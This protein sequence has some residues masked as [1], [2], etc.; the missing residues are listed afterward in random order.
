MPYNIGLVGCGNWSK[1]VTKEIEEHTNFNLK[2]IVCRKRN[3]NIS[4]NINIFNSI[5]EMLDN[6]DLDCIYIAA[7]PETNLEVI[8][9]SN[10]KKI[11]LILEKPLSNSYK[12]SLEIKKIYEANKSIILPNLSNVF[13]SSFNEIKKFVNLNK[14]KIKRVLIN[15]G[16]F[17]Q[18]RNKINPIWDWGFH[19]ISLIHNLFPEDKLFESNFKEI[20]KNNFYGN[21]IVA[22]FNFNINKKINVRILTGNLFK[23]K[24]RVLKIILDNGK[25][26]KCDLI[27]HKVYLDDNLIYKNSETPLNSLLTKF[28]ELIEQNDHNYCYSLIDSSCKT[29]KILEKYYNC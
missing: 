23:N 4:K 27:N 16:S 9:L 21:G 8:K 26:L 19:S 25:H 6:K 3:N 24:S 7:L 5:N 22:K 17:G 14:N 2:S 29:V 11:P 10:F 12:S 18:F 1:I 20:R 15:E 28:N 13:S